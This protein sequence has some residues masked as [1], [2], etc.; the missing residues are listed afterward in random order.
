[1]VTERYHYVEWRYWDGK[2]KVTAELAAV[3]LYDMESDPEE[4]VNISEL[5][6]SKKIINQLA[7]QL[8]A[9]W[10]KAF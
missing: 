3:E 4:N 5:P 10:R 1:M 2:K 6:A 8:Q 9:G 7:Q